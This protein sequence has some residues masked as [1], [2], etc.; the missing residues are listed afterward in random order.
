MRLGREDLGRRDFLVREGAGNRAHDA[1][2][3][4]RVLEGSSDQGGRA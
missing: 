2:L 4:P 1:A 3:Q